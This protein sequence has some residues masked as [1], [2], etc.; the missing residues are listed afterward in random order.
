LVMALTVAPI[1][2]LALRVLASIAAS[3][4]VPLTAAALPG[5]ARSP[6]ELASANSQLT[7][8]GMAGLISG[9]L[10]AA[11]LLATAGP[12]AIFLINSVTFVVSAYL[13]FS[14][15]GSFQDWGEKDSAAKS[16][17]LA[18]GFR[19]LGRERTLLGVSVAY[20]LIFLALGVSAP[21]EIGLSENLGAGSSGYA[22]LMGVWALGG[23]GGAW[24]G[25]RSTRP[26]SAVLVLLIGTAGLV[27]GFAG[28]ASPRIFIGALLAMGFVGISEAI[29][30][31]VLHLLVQ[32]TAPD[33]IR[34]R[35]FASSEAIAQGGLAV[36]LVLSA[37]LIAHLGI[38]SAFS[39]ACAGCIVGAVVLL[40]AALQR[41]ANCSRP[42]AESR[43]PGAGGLL[44]Q[45]PPPPSRSA[46]GR[47][48]PIAAQGG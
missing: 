17:G 21:A 41:R 10:L 11:L 34:S 29:W 24:L 43:A 40:P 12:S 8:A 9:S 7:G 48:E 38:A 31:V 47:Q 32:T 33:G 4:M 36:G 26:E 3:P 25:R 1:A 35:V 6:E 18:A 27:I 23:V 39:A 2:L 14:I 42:M 46:D 22:A 19:F 30:Q 45:G 13:I 20:G 37:P 28:L 15:G 5:I 44:S 16:H